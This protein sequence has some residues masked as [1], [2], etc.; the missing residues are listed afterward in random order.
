MTTFRDIAIN[1]SKQTHG[2]FV[3]RMQPVTKAH[4]DIITRIGKEN[5][6][7][8]IFLVKGKASSKDL[9]KNP[10][11]AETQKKMLEKIAPKNVK[12][13][14]IPSG[15]FVDFLNATTDKNFVVYGGS[16]RIK[17]YEKFS[18][19]LDD[20]KKMKVE[21][22]PRTDDDI[23]ATKVRKALLD[24][25][26]KLFKTLTNSAIHSMYQ[27]LRDEISKT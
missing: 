9:E 13:K 15:F 21:E 20:G 5:A 2:I 26:E 22:I 8:T 18:A 7:G 24:N 11:S 27:T 17:A 23:S 6:T 10:F 16:D 25:N 12:I 3:G 4:A 14:I 19:Y 1:E